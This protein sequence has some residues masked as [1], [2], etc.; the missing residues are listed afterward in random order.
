MDCFKTLYRFKF[1]ASDEVVLIALYEQVIR[2]CKK[3]NSSALILVKLMDKTNN[4]AP[5]LIYKLKGTFR[6][7]GSY[8]S[9]SNYSS[10]NF[11]TEHTEGMHGAMSELMKCQKSLMLKTHNTICHKFYS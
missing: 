4:W 10:V 2:M 6:L 7:R 3:I 5:Y 1:T 9:H 8:I 11:F